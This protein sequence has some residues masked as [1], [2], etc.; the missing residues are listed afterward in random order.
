MLGYLIR[1]AHTT[2][3]PKRE[4]FS[5][6][7]PYDGGSIL[8]G[9]DAVCKTVGIGNIRMRMFDGQVRT[10]TN[11][12]HVPN[13]KKNLLSLVTWEA[14]GYKFSGADGVI[15]FSRG[16][17]KILKGERTTN[18]YKLT[19]IIII[20]DASAVTEKKDTIRLWHMR[21]GHMS[22]RGL[23]TLHKSS[24][25]LGIKY[26]KLGLCKFYI[27]GRQ[28]RVAF[29]TS[30]HKTKDLQDLIHTDVWGLSPVASIGGA[31]YYVTFID[32]FLRKV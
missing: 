15:K 6:Y 28:H 27:M 14:R 22:K 12:W 9:N 32:D 17:M 26:C 7:K 31:R 19:W 21:L 13:L 18:L 1:G 25:L 2:C 30:Q 24:A 10:L 5:T 29:S 16:Y 23:Q 8:M 3:T 20:G 11:V 4:W